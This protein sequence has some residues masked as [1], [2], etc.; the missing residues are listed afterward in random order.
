ML[1]YGLKAKSKY[2][3]PLEFVSSSIDLTKS[4]CETFGDSWAGSAC[5][6]S[7]SQGEASGIAAS[8]QFGQLVMSQARQAHSHGYTPVCGERQESPAGPQSLEATG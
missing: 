7:M 3:F 4:V 6:L 1:L 2:L 8:P 5:P